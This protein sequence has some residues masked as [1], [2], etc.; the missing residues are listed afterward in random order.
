MK[1]VKFLILVILVLHLVITNAISASKSDT[2][3]IK[4]HLTRLTKTQVARSSYHVGQLN[5]AADYIDSI[6]RLYTDSVQR[7]PFRTMRDTFQNVIASFGTE[8]KKRIIVGAHYDVCGDQPGADDNASG[9][10]ALLELA[11]MLKGQKLHYRIDL[12]AYSL[13]EPPYFASDFMGSYMHAKLMADMKADLYG[14]ISIESIGYFKNEPHSQTYPLSI[15]NLW[16]GNKGNF[17]TLVRKLRSGRFADEFCRKFM[18]YKSIRTVNFKGPLS[19]DGISDS[20]HASYWKFGFSALMITDSSDYRNPTYHKA[21]DTMETLDI[22]SI[23][24]VT[25]SIFSALIAL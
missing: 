24:K 5:K 21:S 11:R 3:R 25:D 1:K 23:A 2:L 18:R 8:N 19:I 4:S 16:Y 17:I 6:F 12:V 7:Q 22:G 15:M 14:M 20:D 9:V 10:A 13:E